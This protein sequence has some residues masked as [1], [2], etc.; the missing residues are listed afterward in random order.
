MSDN[1]TEYS[2]ANVQYL[3]I[4]EPFTLESGATL[5]S[6]TIAYH[7]YG[8]L[9]A[10][11]DNVIW[12]CHALTAN[13]DVA[14][15]WPGTVVE[16]G[17]LDPARY[18][19][20]CANKL[21]S[22]YGTTGAT[23]INPATG[24]PYYQDFPLVTIR[25]MAKAHELLAR[26]LGIGQIKLLLG[27]ST[28]GCQAMEWAVEHP[29]RFS[30]V[31][32]MVTLARTTPWIKASSE[33]QRMAIEN[34]PTFLNRLVEGGGD[35]L[36]TARAISM[37]LYRNSTAYDQTQP[38]MDER[39]EGFRSCSYQRYQGKKLRRRFDARSYHRL[40]TALDSHDLGRGRGGVEAA[41]KRIK[42]HAVIVGVDSDIMFP[43]SNIK[44]M[45]MAMPSA[46]YHEIHSD[47]GHDGFLIETPAI[48]RILAP[49]LRH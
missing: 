34:D 19:V 4:N 23:S 30:L 41:L 15:W 8:T 10:A 44:Q 27:G 9:S 5:P 48:S 36:A 28:G 14:D 39:L 45:A 33:S 37:L 1:Y 40:L 38:D 49:L 3:H 24:E 35:G 21:G 29:E 46:E 16:G 11:K 13:S 7:T 12:V 32:F 20:V 26:E 22:C 17:I 2:G 47:F 31:A 18:F 42:A 6:L 25:D 43:A